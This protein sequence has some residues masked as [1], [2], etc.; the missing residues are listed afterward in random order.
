MAL[1]SLIDASDY[2]EKHGVKTEALYPFEM[3]VPTS[4]T[5]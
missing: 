5:D 4:V 3:L 1:C 2:S